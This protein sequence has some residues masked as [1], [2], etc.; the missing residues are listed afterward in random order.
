MELKKNLFNKKR[1]TA[2]ELSQTLQKSVGSWKQKTSNKKSQETTARIRK[3]MG[4]KHNEKLSPEKAQ[5]FA[6]EYGKRLGGYTSGTKVRELEKGLRNPQPQ[7]EKQS[8]SN[9][10]NP[11]NQPIRPSISQQRSGSRFG[12]LVRGM[13]GRNKTTTPNTTPSNRFSQMSQNKPNLSS[14]SNNPNISQKPPI[15]KAT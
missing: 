11:Q 6:Q 1:Q 15:N 14:N 4:I 13:F 5:K 8:I 2:Q 7:T 10:T 12:N 3:E 9:Q